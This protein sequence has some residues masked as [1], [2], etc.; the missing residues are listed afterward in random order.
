MRR[1]KASV[2]VEM[3]A[4][5][6]PDDGSHAKGCEKKL[7]AAHGGRLLIRKLCVRVVLV[8]LDCCPQTEFLVCYRTLAP[9]GKL[10][11]H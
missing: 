9:P 4:A 7:C 5:P 1:G 6:D 2:L 8:A 10:E 11:R 3:V